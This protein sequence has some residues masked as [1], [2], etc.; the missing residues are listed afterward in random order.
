MSES[1]TTLTPGST[2]T[3]PVQPDQATL[4]AMNGPTGSGGGNRDGAGGAIALR[5]DASLDGEY[6][7][8]EAKLYS[9]YMKISYGVGFGAELGCPVGSLVLGK[10]DVI[11]GPKAPLTCIIVGANG[12]WREW[13]AYD[14]NSM[15]RDFP[16]EK[17]AQE[18][19]LRTRNP[20]YGSGQPLRNCAP[21]VNLNLFVRAPEGGAGTS[22]AFNLL[23]GGHTYAPVNFV[24]DRSQYRDIEKMLDQLPKLDAATRGVGAHEGKIS[25][26]YVTLSTRPEVIKRPDASDPAKRSLTVVHLN[27]N[28]L[29]GP[30]NRPLRVEEK[31]KTDISL[32]ADTLAKAANGGAALTAGSEDAPGE[33]EPF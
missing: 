6:T 16:T 5:G 18:A 11:A 15:P 14:A 2:S 12:F 31:V 9:E 27:L 13:K 30:D 1:N 32:L 4:D 10:K 19:G 3:E 25:A 8:A 29:L 21:A 28:P 17:A 26:F 20:P 24:V 23:L 7:P 22:M 33:E